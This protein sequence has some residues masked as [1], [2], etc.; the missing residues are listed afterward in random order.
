MT[1]LSDFLSSCGSETPAK[2][3]VEQN[4]RINQA[5]AIQAPAA[6]AHT[7]YV[8][9]IA[10][11]TNPAVRIG[12]RGNETLVSVGGNH[13]WADVLFVDGVAQEVRIGNPGR[14]GTSTYAPDPKLM[15]EL[16]KITTSL[17]PQR[18]GASN[19][20]DGVA[21]AA[22]ANRFGETTGFGAAPKMAGYETFCTTRPDG[23][24]R[25]L[26]T[27]HDGL[28]RMGLATPP[29]NRTADRLAAQRTRLVPA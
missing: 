10:S 27:V 24:E 13:L 6:L 11:Q 26:Q 9:Q 18:G 5:A 25:A 29:Y 16:A 20:H 28:T 17:A 19:D 21:L 14:S 22:L 3:S 1:A 12:Y 15:S 4:A 2:F 23:R 7:S 8:H